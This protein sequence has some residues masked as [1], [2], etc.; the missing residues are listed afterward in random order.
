MLCRTISDAIKKLQ[1]RV[2]TQE[3]LG[4][5]DEEQQ[6]QLNT[7]FFDF[8]FIDSKQFL[9][10]HWFQLKTTK[11]YHPPF[12]FYLFFIFLFLNHTCYSTYMAGSALGSS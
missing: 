8:R 1:K 3:D 10:L 12:L 2:C 9:T 6:T 11:L 4:W 5:K 7:D